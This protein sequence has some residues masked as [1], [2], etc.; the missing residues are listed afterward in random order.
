MAAIAP[1]IGIALG[2]APPVVAPQLPH[3]A[4]PGTITG[5]IL[6]E[7]VA[8]TST[9]I[10]Q[11]M[12]RS[13]NHLVTNIPDANDPNYDNVMRRMTDEVLSSDTLVTYLTATN[14]WNGVDVVPP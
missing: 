11:E 13:F 8:M 12:E 1:P 4:D 10:T 6:D 9:V 3:S 2:G 14:R 7:T 5:W